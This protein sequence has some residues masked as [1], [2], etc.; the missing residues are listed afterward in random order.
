VSGRA[1]LFT[2]D[3]GAYDRFM[4]RYSTLLAPVFAEAAG[5]RAGMRLLDVGC[6]PGAL[7]AELVERV[8]AAS[9]AAA[10]PS[11]PFVD[12]IRA[13]LP[14]VDVRVA[15]A[16]ELPFGDDEFDASLAQLVFH[17][18]R[19]PGRGLAELRRVTRPGGTIAACTWDAREGMRLLRSFWDAALEL[20]ERAPDEAKTVRFTEARELEELFLDGGLADVRVEALTVAAAYTGFD[21]LWS[22]VLG[23]VGPV[24]AY[25]AGLDD[26][27]REEL[28]A[29]WRERVGD[30]TGSFSLTARAWAAFGTA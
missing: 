16:E 27:R 19:N 18:L 8:G 14:G 2:V 17:F 13:R 5:V 26:A 24:G 6:G 1:D 28:S 11:A 29:T 12:A 20:D 25:V 22:S 10:D 9:V 15:P 7:S 23:G 3:A 4:G 30:P 21:E